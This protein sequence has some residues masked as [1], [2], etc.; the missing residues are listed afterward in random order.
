MD[1]F[2][3]GGFHQRTR[4]VL[5]DPS[6]GS[7]TTPAGKAC[8]HTEENMPCNSRAQCVAIME[9][10]SQ[11]TPAPTPLDGDLHAILNASANHTVH[12]EANAAQLTATSAPTA[13]PTEPP[14]HYVSKSCKWNYS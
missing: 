1:S 11:A 10:E 8:P 6:D 7:A 2:E 5:L 12:T 14:F 3:D 13:V 9:L 4:T